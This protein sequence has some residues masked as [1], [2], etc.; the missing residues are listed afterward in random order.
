MK[1]SRYRLAD[2][3]LVQFVGYVMT[4]AGFQILFGWG[5]AMLCGGCV[6]MFGGTLAVRNRPDTG[7]GS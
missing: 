7:G 5:W 6:A 1:M 3:L 4:V 2:L